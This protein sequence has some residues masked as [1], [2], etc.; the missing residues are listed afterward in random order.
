MVGNASNWEMQDDQRRSLSLEQDMARESSVK[1]GNVAALTAR[2]SPESRG[3]R[4]SAFSLE[5]GSCD[6]RPQLSNRSE[7]TLRHMLSAVTSPISS[8]GYNKVDTHQP[9]CGNLDWPRMLPCCIQWINGW[10]ADAIVRELFRA[11]C[12]PFS[13]SAPTT[14]VF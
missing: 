8:S 10:L 3:P 12:R 1:S 11:S 13:A 4:D 14:N 6:R 2:E 7:I 5:I 9:E